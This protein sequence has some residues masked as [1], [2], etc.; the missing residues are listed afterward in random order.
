MKFANCIRPL[1]AAAGLG[2]CI[3]AAAQQPIG[4][5]LSSDSTIKGSVVMASGAPKLTSGS[6]VTAGGDTARVRLDR[7]GQLHVCPG[8][9]VTVNAS[10]DGG[11]LMMSLSNG[12][13]ETHYKIPAIADVVMTPDFRILLAG[14]GEFDLA[15]S[16]NQK[17]DTCVASL[18]DSAS[19]LVNELLGDGVYQVRARDTVVF[20]GGKVAGAST[21]ERDCGC[22]A[23]RPVQRAA[24]PERPPLWFSAPWQ[25]LPSWS[26]DAAV[27]VPPPDHAFAA[28]L[29]P[30][31]Q[32]PADES[33]TAPPP[34]LAPSDVHVTVDAPFVFRAAAPPP[35]VIPAKISVTGLPM[36]ELPLTQVA[37]PVAVAESGA[38]QPQT[39]KPKKK[40][41]LFGRVRGFFASLF[42]GS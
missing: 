42:S 27:V 5:V 29:P 4:E 13:L 25:S 40:K 36:A 23:P 22:P 1:A 24:I 37:A 3:T 28:P 35:A 30:L 2:L 14:P 41:G 21:E 33:L 8:S 20:H 10:G 34:A 32:L 17:G 26:D 7:G 19:V 11:R 16:T 15:V 12:A 9:T 6:A 31:P 18:S 39:T 38:F